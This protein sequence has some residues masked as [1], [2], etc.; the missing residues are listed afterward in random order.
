[1]ADPATPE[2]KGPSRLLHDRRWRAVIA[3]AAAFALV[4]ALLACAGLNMA[5]NLERAGIASG[6]GFLDQVAGFEISQ[7][8]IEYSRAS[9][10]ARAFWVGLLNTLAVSAVCIAASTVL[11]FLLGLLRLS[12]NWLAARLA[13]VYVE[14]VRNVPLLLQILFWYIA[15]LNPLP[16]PRQ[17]LDLGGVAYL[18]NRGL[19]L[20]WPQWERGGLAV[21]L[22][23]AAGLALAWGFAAWARR[24]RVR[25]GRSLPVWRLGALLAALPPALAWALAD[26]R[27]EWSIPALSGFNF[28]GGGTVEPEFIALALAL[29]L[30]TA[31]FIAENVRAGIQAVPRGQ[32]EAAASLGLRPWRVMRLVVVPQA[33]RVIIPP[34]TSQHMTLV[35]N[36][37]LAVVIG[38]PDLMSVFAGTTLNQTGQAVEIIAITMLVYLAVS[39]VISLIMNWYNDAMALKGR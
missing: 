18:C 26:A 19:V 23:L 34:L 39:I 12:P 6:F 11:G 2:P 8:L 22:A 3:Q 33:M 32:I 37:S 4:A 14:V 13:G 20:P 25:T 27:V 36:S 1:M 28:R 29:T 5:R 21:G 9:T 17:A 16:P 30:Y 35:K 7:T 10:Y 31:G 24:R 38:Y 15:V